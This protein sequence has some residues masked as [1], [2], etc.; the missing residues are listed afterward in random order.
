MDDKLKRFMGEYQTYVNHSDKISCR[1]IQFLKDNPVSKKVKIFHSKFPTY[2][3]LLFLIIFWFAFIKEDN[4]VWKL[5][6]QLTHNETQQQKLEK[7]LNDATRQISSKSLELKKL[8]IQIKEAQKQNADSLAS[9]KISDLEKEIMKLRNLNE[10]YPKDNQFMRAADCRYNELIDSKASD[11]EKIFAENA[12]RFAVRGLGSDFEK[13]QPIIDKAFSKALDFGRTEPVL[14]SIKPRVKK[15]ELYYQ[16]YKIARANKESKEALDTLLKVIFYDINN[17]DYWA[18]AASLYLEDWDGKAVYSP[19]KAALYGKI[20]VLLKP[21]DPFAYWGLAKAYICLEKYQES[22][23]IISKALELSKFEAATYSNWKG[24][25]GRANFTA[26]KGQCLLLSRDYAGA[27]EYLQTALTL[28]PDI[29]WVHAILDEALS[30]LRKVAKKVY[31]DDKKDFGLHL[32]VRNRV[33]VVKDVIKGSYAELS[34]IKVSD[35]IL[36]ID[37]LLPFDQ[38]QHEQVSSNIINVAKGRKYS[39]LLE[40][41]RGTNSFY[42]LVERKV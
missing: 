15:A 16:I 5:K 19:E 22:E 36:K 27:R 26:L 33:I 12:L 11:A 28:N 32:E 40:I 41:Q 34:G 25:I 23:R 38:K 42:I 4:K 21:R 9:K 3:I 10:L 24:D 30:P 13:I 35:I 18:K 1:I 29:K 7:N 6:N 14:L 39:V 37:G 20:A 31:I 2:S 8:K 17:W